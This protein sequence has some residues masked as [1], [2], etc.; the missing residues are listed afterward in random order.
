[1]QLVNAPESAARCVRGRCA[2][3]TATT[4]VYDIASRPWLLPAIVKAAGDRGVG[5]FLGDLA[6]QMRQPDPARRPTFTTLV[7]TVDARIRLR[8]RLL[9]EEAVA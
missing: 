3:L 8:G 1:M 4:H 6:Q 7:K 2:R 9:R 5:V